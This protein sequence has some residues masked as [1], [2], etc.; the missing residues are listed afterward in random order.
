MSRS[1]PIGK[2]MCHFAQFAVADQAEW[3]AFEQHGAGLPSI[4]RC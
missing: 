2:M 4:V 3:S 1:R